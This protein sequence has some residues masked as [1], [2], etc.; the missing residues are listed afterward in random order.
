MSVGSRDNYYGPI[1]N[2]SMDIF[3]FSQGKRIWKLNIKNWLRDMRIGFKNNY[4]GLPFYPLDVIGSE[5]VKI[6]CKYRF[7]EFTQSL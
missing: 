2:A 3:N 6:T 4:I 1:T 7:F 5:P